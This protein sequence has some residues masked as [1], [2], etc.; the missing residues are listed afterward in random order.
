MVSIESGKQI[1]DAACIGLHG[2]AVD[3]NSHR[4]RMVSP[5]Q[6]GFSQIMSKVAKMKTGI[7][8]GML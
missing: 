8:T 7:R 3:F 1:C 5:D 4:I 6:L 2:G